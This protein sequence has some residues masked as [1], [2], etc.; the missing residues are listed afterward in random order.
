MLNILF[1]DN[2]PNILLGLQRLLHPTRSEWSLAFAQSGTQALEILS[3]QN[4]DVIVSDLKMPDMD[5]AQLLTQVC[6]KYPQT[7]RIILS[8]DAEKNLSL[9]GISLAHQFLAKP[10]D[11]EILRTTISRVFALRNI[12]SNAKLRRL[13]SAM[14]IVPSLPALYTQLTE[15]LNRPSPSIKKVCEIIQQDIGMTAKILQIVNS[16]FFGLQRKIS[17]TREA[18]LFLGLDTTSTLALSLDIFSQLENQP[19]QSTV[20]NLWAHSLRVA[21]IAYKISLNEIPGLAV[22]AFTAGM[23]HDI[24][25]AI[26]A[27]NLPQEF[28]TARSLM[29]TRHL[30]QSAAEQQVYGATHAA[31]G[32]YLLSLWGL[33]TPIVE[34]VA[35]HH[36]PNAYQAN[37]FTA[38]T[39]VHVANAVVNN[40]DCDI[41]ASPEQYLDSA[42]LLRLQLG[43]RFPFWYATCLKNEAPATQ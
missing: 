37:S 35:F 39:A 22:D 15:E 17:T 2:E 33:P 21:K 25:Q 9:R 24:G 30:A 36:E 29:E 31:L 23:L 27:V 16:A 19:L 43:E 20:N 13:L 5:G 10:C 42:Y 11:T 3:Q 6:N 4:V 28:A 32:A 14:R 1:V 8:G 34:A 12:L 41:L 26:L 18:V 38:L 7:I 40:F